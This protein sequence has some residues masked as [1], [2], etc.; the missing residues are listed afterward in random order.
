MTRGAAGGAPGRASNGP[1]TDARLAQRSGGFLN[2]MGP[3]ITTY[4]LRVTDGPA[5]PLP[6]TEAAVLCNAVALTMSDIAEHPHR[7]AGTDIRQY[8][9]LHGDEDVPDPLLTALQLSRS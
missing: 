6:L 8:D 5:S 2:A 4:A 1:A 7:A 9:S 3:P